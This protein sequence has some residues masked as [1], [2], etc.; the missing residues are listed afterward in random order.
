[1]QSSVARQPKRADGQAFSGERH[2]KT[3]SHGQRTAHNTVRTSGLAMEWQEKYRMSKE[4][5][6]RIR[7]KIEIT[8]RCFTAR[9]YHVYTNN[10]IL[11]EFSGALSSDDARLP[12]SN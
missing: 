12:K 7:I 1:M 5:C 11:T 10:V 3:E 9:Y 4:R 2:G 8:N 6:Y